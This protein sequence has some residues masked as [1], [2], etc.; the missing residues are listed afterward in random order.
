M[1]RFDTEAK[2]NELGNGLSQ[3]KINRNVTHHYINS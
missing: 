3:N 1:T 2:E